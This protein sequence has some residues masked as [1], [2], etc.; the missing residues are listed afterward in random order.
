MVFVILLQVCFRYLFNNA[1]PWPDE[2]ARF[3]MLWMT[4]L[5]AP[6]A[7]RVGGFVTIDMLG[8]AL[9]RGRGACRSFAT[10]EANS[11]RTSASSYRSRGCGISTRS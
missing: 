5:I 3:C 8:R 7:Y 1:L 9:P 2:A 11:R 6:A 10:S 4:G